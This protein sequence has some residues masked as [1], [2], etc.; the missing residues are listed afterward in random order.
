MDSKQLIKY[1]LI[2]VGVY[3]IYRQF[4]PQVGAG[5]GPTPGNQPSTTPPSPYTPPPTTTAQVQAPMRVTEAQLVQWATNKQ[6]A[7]TAPR[8]V[9]YTIDEWNWFRQQ[10]GQPYF[11]A[12][13]VPG[14]TNDNRGT[15]KFS[16]S[17]YWAAVKAGGMA[18]LRGFGVQAFADQ[19]RNFTWLM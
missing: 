18:G 15:I 16:A 9:T 5:P 3:L 11:E 6:A 13:A 10:A 2:G 4:L 8:N 7:Q 1:A 14:I 17:A 19:Y 12:L